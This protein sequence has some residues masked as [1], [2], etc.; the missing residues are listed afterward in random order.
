VSSARARGRSAKFIQELL[1]AYGEPGVEDLEAF[2]E[3]HTLYEIVWQAY[4]T[5]Q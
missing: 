3:A 5:P 2:L 4:R 1:A